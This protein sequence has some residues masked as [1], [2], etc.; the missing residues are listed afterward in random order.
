[1][2]RA[3]KMIEDFSQ[4]DKRLYYFNSATPLLDG[5]GRPN[6]ELFLSDRLH[7]NDKGYELWTKLL[8]PVI[9]QAMTQ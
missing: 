2:R 1:M 4:K 9:K 8:T 5:T 6:D 7:L 3:N